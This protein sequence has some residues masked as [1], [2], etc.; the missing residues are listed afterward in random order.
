MSTITLPNIRVGSDLI[1]RVRLKDNG[2]AI[3]WSTLSGI[4]AHLYSDA[5]RALAGRCDVAVDGEDP[6]LLV[7]RYAAT[8][9]QYLGKNRI[10]VQA[11]YRGSTKTYDKPVVNFVR[12]TADTEGEEI[13]IDDPDVDVEIEVED[14]SSSVL[15]EAI[16]AA[17]AAADRANDTADSLAEVE[18][19]VEAAEALRV[20][21]EE[22]REDAEEARA[23]AEL[24][25]VDEEAVRVSAEDGRVSAENAREAAEDLRDE[26]E[27]AREEAEDDRAD[28]EDAREAA[29]ALRVTAE[30]ARVTAETARESQASADHSTAAAD[31]SQAA[32]DHTQAASDHTAAAADHTQAGTDHT[33][34]AADHVTAGEDHTQALADHAVMAGYD[35][36]LGAVE[37]EVSQLE[38]KVD[39]IV[40]G[41]S[42]TPGEYYKYSPKGL[43]YD[44]DFGLSD[45]IKVSKGDSVTWH[46][47][48]A[49]SLNMCM[50]CFDS[51][52]NKVNDWTNNVAKERTISN[53]MSSGS[54]T[55]YYVRASFL[56][57]QLKN[58]YV[59]VNGTVVWTAKET[60]FTHEIKE[61]KSSALEVSGK[62][63]GKYFTK[64]S[65]FAYDDAYGISDKIPVPKG[66]TV[67]W[68]SSA[69]DNTYA[70]AVYRSGGALPFTRYI[71]YLNSRTI[72]NFLGTDADSL[73]YIQVSYKLDDDRAAVIVNGVTVWQNKP[74]WKEINNVGKVKKS[75]SLGDYE[76]VGYIGSSSNAWNT[77]D[78]VSYLVPVTPMDR[79][80]IV[81]GTQPVYYA[82]LASNEKTG[83]TADFSGA[84]KVWVLAAGER[85]EL[86]IEYGTAFV[87]ISGTYETGG[88]DHT[89]TVLKMVY[90]DDIPAPTPT[91][92]PTQ[93]EDA[94]Y[95]PA[96]SS[97]VFNANNGTSK[98]VWDNYIY[99]FID[100]E[101]KTLNTGN[102]A[103]NSLDNKDNSFAIIYNPD[104]NKL[105]L[106]NTNND[107][108]GKY[109]FAT[110]R[111]NNA[112]TAVNYFE[113]C[114]LPTA[115]DGVSQSVSANKLQVGTF[116]SSYNETDVSTVR[117][118]FSNLINGTDD[119]ETFL[120]FS[121]PHL[122]PSSRYET[123]TETV[124]DKYIS[125]L[126]KYY[127]SLPLD[128]CIC[129]GDFLNY[130]TNAEACDYLGY[131][132][133]FMRKLFK[134]Y[135]PCLGNHDVNPYDPN[136]FANA[137]SYT[138]LRNLWFRDEGNDYYSF[139]GKNTKFYVLNSGPSYFKTMTNNTYP[140]LV[141]NRWEQVDW[142]AK[143][144]LADDAPNSVI[145][146][147][148]YSNASG[149][150][151][152]AWYD[153]NTTNGSDGIIEFGLN[154]REVAIAYNNRESITKNGETY[155]FSGK[156]G[157]V[158]FILCGHTHF[159][160]VDASMSLPVVCITNLEGG[161]IVDG[162]YSRTLTP[163]FDC[164][165][166]DITNDA[167]YMERVGAAVSRR[168]HYLPTAVSGTEELTTSLSGEVT[169]SSDNTSVAT[170][171]N[172]I[173]TGV[174]SGCTSIV[175]T[176][177]SGEQEYWVVKVS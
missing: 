22:A 15:D 123:M 57:A 54:D 107:L 19:A 149:S 169:W 67:I 86:N 151:P 90:Y 51:S 42:Y 159:D 58:V 92:T 109:V 4:K 144:L 168:I 48:S 8:K 33:T 56:I 91:P 6:T 81:A 70:M 141:N 1:M 25:R 99:F 131:F 21:A 41:L 129:G 89:P 88:V 52:G 138:T 74:M 63:E 16:Y 29:E 31:H 20:T 108:A 177:E 126:Q 97:G 158:L 10:I 116:N 174:A 117:R 143:K 102:L 45:P 32:A 115:I 98:F 111:W 23:A 110:G 5:Q 120:F 125:A 72:E 155:D 82:L 127:N 59:S 172:G 68:A 156:I 139:D 113:F 11:Q 28:A 50:F 7:C 47:N 173:V 171:S 30:A 93:S 114:V 104:T 27:D 35:T 166:L 18:T 60:S 17:L 152:S 128:Y 175:A 40:S 65:Y 145:V 100:G 135:R 133:G 71:N 36:R 106:V 13:T 170:V 96:V 165:L 164:C 75:I 12:W 55:T 66:A 176:A 137:L 94:R 76:T 136:S 80:T 37:G 153:V 160:F 124:R 64:D 62:E 77:E 78:G 44:S 79:I 26:A 154:I 73:F 43:A 61:L 84:D 14:V 147:H 140:D 132:D 134:N 103:Y 150:N 9:M 121:D 49:A 24:A 122:S 101:K 105:V 69:A 163:T 85:S 38:A 148:A 34:A 146:M 142:F 130:H 46:Y 87:W 162:S 157:N 161:Q 53:I 2:V 95:A 119:I 3:D 83:E 112:K 118:K 39:D 167:L